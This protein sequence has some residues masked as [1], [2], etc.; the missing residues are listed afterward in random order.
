MSKYK[1]GVSA[2]GYQ[3][4][5]YL[6]RVLEPWLLSDC[7]ISITHGL[8]PEVHALGYPILSTDNTIEIIKSHTNS[9]IIDFQV[10]DKPTYEKDIR[11][12]TL[13]ALFKH[14]FEY[15]ILLD[16]QDELY[17]LQNIADITAYIDK[18]EFIPWFRV[19][20]KNYIDLNGKIVTTTD[21]NPP[22]IW[23][24]A[25]EGGIKE[26][27]YDNDIMFNSG[28]K[29]E[30]LPHLKIPKVYVDHYSWTGSHEYLKRKVDF[31][32]R[33]Y[34]HCSYLFDEAKK[35]LQINKEYYNKYNL[36]IPDFQ[37]G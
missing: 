34:G 4:E 35:T 9:N 5:H 22:R 20:F 30:Q 21:F 18:N 17:S 23:R 27:Y 12:T 25:A 19:G 31:Q 24:M 11:N 7:V 2:I 26:F 3:V 33:H 8:F 13:K 10:L 32:N 29:A 16:L 14:D 37:N 28:K 6:E 36:P 15:L 1:F